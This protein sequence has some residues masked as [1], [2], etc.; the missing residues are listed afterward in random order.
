MLSENPIFKGT[1]LQA[2]T[3]QHHKYSESQILV[4]FE[5]KCDVETPMHRFL[6]SVEQQQRS[7]LDTMFKVDI[8]TRQYQ[9]SGLS[10]G[11]QT[12]DC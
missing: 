7:H 6:E 12:G 8:W 1:G 2:Y 3:L 9:I 10:Q 11:C 4:R 5:H